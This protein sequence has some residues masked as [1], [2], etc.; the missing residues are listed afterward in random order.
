MELFASN[1]TVS[2]LEQASSDRTDV[3]SIAMQIELAWYLR[4][5]DGQRALRLCESAEQAL[6]SLQIDTREQNQTQARIFLIRAE[7]SWLKTDF[8]NARQQINSALQLFSAIADHQGQADGHWLA[9]QIETDAGEIL[10]QQQELS[11]CMEEAELAQDQIRYEIA[12]AC[13]ARH[14]VLR[15]R[16]PDE[17]QWVRHFES[18]S[19]QHNQGLSTWVFDFLGVQAGQYSDFATA[20]TQLIRATEAALNSGQITRAIVISA[21]IC[22]SLAGLRDTE[23]SLKWGQHA[24]QLAR[25]KAWPISLGISLTQM[26][27]AFRK[28]DQ[29]DSAKELLNE[30]LQTLH[31]VT[32]SR[33]Y[34][35]ALRSLADIALAQ[36]EYD[37]AHSYFKQLQ[38][39]PV[40][41]L[42]QDFQCI[43]LRGQAQAL[44]HLNQSDAALVAA[45]TALAIADLNNYPDYQI[46]SL[47]ALA[48]IFSTY[49]DL[50]KS[51]L[52]EGK[53][54]LHFLLQAVEIG[55]KI[56]DY[57]ISDKLYARIADEYAKLED[58]S[59]AYA[60]SLLAFSSREKSLNVDIKN[61]AIAM[62]LRLQTEKAVSENEHHKAIVEE[63]QRRATIL[64]QA[65]ETL[66][67]LGTIGQEITTQ[68]QLDNIYQVISHHV[69]ALLDAT[70][71]SIFLLDST[72]SIL[73][74]TYGMEAGKRLPQHEFSV[75]SQIYYSSR[76]VR[77]RH[78]ILVDNF[79][80]VNAAAQLPD[81]LTMESLLFSPLIVADRI[82]G[83]MTMQSPRKYAYQERERLIFRT[84]CSYSA[85]ALDNAHAYSQLMD[86]RNQLVDQEKMA[87]L[88]SLVAGVA[89][90]MN[91][92][93][94]NS[95]LIASTISERTKTL[96]NQIENQSLKRTELLDYL[97]N[98]KE[99]SK[100]ILNGLTTAATMLSSFK[101]VAVDRNTEHKRQFNLRTTCQDIAASI[102]NRI[103]NSGHELQL[104]IPD[105]IEM[106]SYPGPLGQVVTNMIENALLHAFADRSHGHMIIAAERYGTDQIRLQFSD[107]GNGISEKNIGHIFEPFFS[108][109][110][111]Q[112]GSGLGLSISYNII[113][114]ILHGQLNVKSKE[115][116]GTCFTML[117]PIEAPD[118]KD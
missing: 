26:A 117:L 114:S 7:S 20:T 41:Q 10:R 34:I 11:M 110:F 2:T 47:C 58:F 111:G 99:G 91:T 90:E 4:Q 40:A 76:C 106:K 101:Q 85:I 73:T 116:E 115:G 64:E 87:A 65:N 67:V 31:K 118:M 108:T 24:L 72:N 80:T 89:H 38:E 49:P 77:E 103:T 70:H 107:D 3:A 54:S 12:N 63:Q 35:I 13:M 94:G 88:G 30:A 29:L 81:T 51:E 6:S 93:I 23:G 46:A 52:N 97:N 79:E 100:L 102:R 69:N 39:H 60:Y 18:L 112:G 104:L 17:E 68:L 37:N 21:N 45:Q 84:L 32:E 74:L 19:T 28:I 8:Q 95:L 61:S 96:S 113:T 82:I 15:M 33:S 25:P 1:E 56:Q 83:V 75:D 78:E 5:R 98:V 86:A 57:A 50:C 43:A 53:S 92:P 27:D 16:D 36:S 48:D 9:A 42:Q 55:E 71:F 109:R 44:L 22:Y 105:D 59:N 62:Q 66:S 14:K